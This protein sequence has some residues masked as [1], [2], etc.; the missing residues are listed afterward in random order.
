MLLLTLILLPLAAAALAYGLD[1]ARR[2]WVLVSTALLHTVLVMALWDRPEQRALAGWLA[3]DDAGRIVLTLVS[4]LFLAVSQ[5]AVGFLRTEASRG[6]LGGR[7]FVSCMLAFVA[8][9]TL[10]CLSHH[11]ALLWVGMESS[12]L[13]VAPLALDRRDRRSLEAIWKYLMLSSVGIALALFGVFLLATAQP[14]GAGRPLVLEDL[15]RHGAALDPAWLRAAF[16]FALIGFGTKMGLAPMHSWKP[17]VYGEAS[18]LVAAL[19]AGALTSCA[20]LGVARVA[21]VCFAAGQGDFIR[22]MLVGFGLV[23]L[24]IAAAFIVGQGDLRRLLAY[25]SVEHMGLLVL[26]LGVGGAGAWGAVLHTLNNGLAKGLSFLV[27]GNIVLSS[28]TSAASQLRG[29][30]RTMPVNRGLLLTALF[31]ITGAP[32]F[33]LFLSE[34]TILRG[35]F[36][37]GHPVI[38]GLTVTLLVVIFVGVAAMIL[39]LVYG[40]RDDSG[41]SNLEHPGLERRELVVAPAMIALVLLGLG[42]YLPEPLTTALAGAARALGGSAP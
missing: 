35:A 37:E 7:V 38:A 41:E 20:F 39:E 29:V 40:A 16:V 19:M 9:A 8:A 42:V 21:A 31:V 12:T 32:P 1:A 14:S 3:V 28:G 22:P 26:G 6:A 10:V 27:A 18:G 25:S 36:A 24:A 15:L 17:D 11:L 2:R 5:Y 4:V 30:L 23:S 34:F 13:A 33:G